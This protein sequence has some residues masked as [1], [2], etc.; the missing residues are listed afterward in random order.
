LSLPRRLC[1][2]RG[3]I[4]NGV[5]WK[6]AR[7]PRSSLIQLE[8][9]AREVG[10]AD[11]WPPAEAGA[12]WRP[13]FSWHGARGHEPAWSRSVDGCGGRW[14]RSSSRSLA[15]VGSS[16]VAGTTRAAFRRRLKWTRRS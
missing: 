1:P 15:G 11:P 10:A 5:E 12:P 14:R 6:P 13:G 8:K 2:R 16:S 7:K 9:A 3:V 4:L